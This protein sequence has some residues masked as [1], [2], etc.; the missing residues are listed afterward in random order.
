MS[1]SGS[2]KSP[3]MN[4]QEKEFVPAERTP[5]VST[6]TGKPSTLKRIGG[7]I[8]AVS[9]FNPGHEPKHM[10]DGDTA[11]FWHTRFQPDFAP[12]PHYVVLELP[13]ET[14][15]AGLAY[16]PR[17]KPSGR[18]LA[19][20]VSVSDDGE[21]WNAPVVK[22]RFDGEAIAEQRV[23]FPAPIAKRYARFEV[24][25]ALSAGG[26]LIAAIGELDVLLD[27]RRP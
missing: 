23:M 4:V 14:V 1:A 7:K 5:L 10:L 22:G 26:Q 17:G 13:A 16:T 21:T 6:R 9:S 20:E 25:D 12:P 24:T 11:T 3:L 15:V 19:Y 27:R 18:V 2:P 8:A